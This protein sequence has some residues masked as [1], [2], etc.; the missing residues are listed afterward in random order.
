MRRPGVRF[1]PD[2]PSLNISMIEVNK[3]NRIE[4]LDVLRGLACIMVVLG[5]YI[6]EIGPALNKQL[7]ALAGLGGKGV[8]LFFMISGFVI[9][10]TLEN[11]RKPI[12]FIVS[13]FARL[14]P[15]YWAAVILSFILLKCFQLD[16][17]HVSLQ[18]LLLNLTMLPSCFGTE[19]L[20][21]VYWTL[22]VE[23]VFY[24]WMFLLLVS[25]GL[26]YI[27]YYLLAI[28]FISGVFVVCEN[29]IAGQPMFSMVNNILILDHVYW[30]ALGIEFYKFF[31]YRDL[32]GEGLLVIAAAVIVMVLRGFSTENC[33]INLGLLL[34]FGAAVLI[35]MHVFLKPLQYLGLI[36]YALYLIH[37]NLGRAFITQLTGAGYNQWAVFLLILTA[38]LTLAHAL[39]FTIEMPARQAIRNAYNRLRRAS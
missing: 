29:A 32:K 6:Q 15:A 11:T 35:K 17:D 3:S 23:L 13:R 37:S 21:K 4:M 24:A 28:L 22:R 30:F 10:M 20:D 9:F 26:K 18:N 1:P 16:Q 33:L 38:A 8:W 14:F 2:P 25:N 12:D 7:Y 39:T 36:S 19:N 27:D 5:H 34:V 31:K